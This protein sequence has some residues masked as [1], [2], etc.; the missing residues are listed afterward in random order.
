[1]RSFFYYS[2]KI[3]QPSPDGKDAI[4]PPPKIKINEGTKGR[5]EVIS[6]DTV[7]NRLELDKLDPVLSKDTNESKSSVNENTPQSAVEIVEFSPKNM[8]TVWN[9]DVNVSSTVF[10]NSPALS[11]ERLDDKEMISMSL[12]EDIVTVQLEQFRLNEDEKNKSNELRNE[13]DNEWCVTF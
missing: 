4:N 6:S 2:A 9:K 8:E 11:M 7:T 13:D 5:A 1:M 12:A 3:L 10:P